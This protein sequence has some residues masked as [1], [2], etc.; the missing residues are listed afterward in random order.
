MPVLFI[1]GLSVHNNQEFC[2]ID[3][4]KR[5]E[6][7]QNIFGRGEKSGSYPLS[8]Q[9]ESNRLGFFAFLIQIRRQNKPWHKKYDWENGV[10][11]REKFLAGRKPRS[12]PGEYTLGIL[13]VPTQISPLGAS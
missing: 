4:Q 10:G 13:R 12:G 1:T 2:T 5:E 9:G 11:Q 3:E 6:R 7:E 8:P